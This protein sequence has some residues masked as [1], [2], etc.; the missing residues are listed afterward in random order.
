MN[1]NK[2]L[3]GLMAA[4]MICA[5][6]SCSST[7]KTGKTSAPAPAPS[8]EETVA[9]VP[10]QHP[11]KAEQ[12]GG[13]IAG[14]PIDRAASSGSPASQLANKLNGEWIIVEAGK[15]KISRDEEM[16]YVNF[17]EGDGKFY[18]FNGCNVLNGNFLFKGED[19]ILFSNVITTQQYCPDVKFDMAINSI[20][21]DGAAVSA[22]VEKVGNETYLYMASSGGAKMTLRKHNLEVLNGLW[23]FSTIDDQKV[24]IDGVNIFFDIPEQTVHGNTGCNSFNGGIAIDPQK[25]NAISF[26][27]MAVTMRMCE[28]SDVERQMLVALE[29]TVTY[30]VDGNTLILYGDRG[31]KVATLV[32]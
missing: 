22:R 18:A 14:T 10:A 1:S 28:N 31:Q 20:L 9:P 13:N 23:K 26:S 17:T 2:I 27:Q 12:T 15:H 4:A 11:V 6:A 25:A 5:M 19:E 3:S 30:S 29:E 24:G 32:R 21:A 8:Q 7:K 16:P